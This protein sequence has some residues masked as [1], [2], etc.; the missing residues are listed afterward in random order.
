M[1]NET[2]VKDAS[3]ESVDCVPD[4]SVE[5]IA[6]MTLNEAKSNIYLLWGMC[7]AGQLSKTFIDRKFAKAIIALQNRCG[8][9]IIPGDEPKEIPLLY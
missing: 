9:Q 3:I 1:K 6:K 2:C 5:S 8:V 4:L 7:M